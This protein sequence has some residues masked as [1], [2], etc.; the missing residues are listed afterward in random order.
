MTCKVCDKVYTG[1]SVHRA[2][3]NLAEHVKRVHGMGL[4]QYR[5]KYETSAAEQQRADAVRAEREARRNDAMNDVQVPDNFFDGGE[6]D[7][8]GQVDNADQPNEPSETSEPVVALITLVE[9]FNK[10][11]AAGAKVRDYF[12][13]E[14]YEVLRRVMVERAT[15]PP[16]K[17]S[18]VGYWQAVRRCVEKLARDDAP[19]RFNLSDDHWLERFPRE[20]LEALH[21]DLLPAAQWPARLRGVPHVVQHQFAMILGK[22]VAVSGGGAGWGGSDRHANNAVAVG[23]RAGA[24]R[25]CR[26]CHRVAGVAEVG[27]APRHF[28]ARVRRQGAPRELCR[29]LGSIIWVDSGSILGRFWV[30]SFR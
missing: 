22:L 6:L 18:I 15:K 2:R 14:G 13:G 7:F 16:S 3:A 10:R 27:D 17:K 8:G 21:H 20:L 24:Q 29:G 11:Y 9:A 12:E 19:G 30:D 28:A 1:R 5:N 25:R 26:A 23:D 4:V